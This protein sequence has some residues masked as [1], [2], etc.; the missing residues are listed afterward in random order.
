M[1]QTIVGLLKERTGHFAFESG[2]HGATW[3][4]LEKLFLEPG[5]VRPIVE[6]LSARLARHAPEAICGPLTEGAFLALLVALELGLPFAY[7]QRE[8]R[9][10]AAIYRIAPALAAELHGLRVA[11]IDD[12]INAGSA[13]SAT[14]AALKAAGAQP[15]ALGA[16]AVY[17]GAAAAL[18]SAQELPLE[19]LDTRP[20][21]IW[22][23]ADCPL[24]A[25]GIPL[26]Q[27][28]V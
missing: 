7:T 4:E 1:R 23:A 20:G 14:L 28:A 10:G 15:V 21:R 8:H 26:D 22:D 9:D 24:C 18:A 27:V 16:M 12:V 5:K 19:T 3:L 13:V 11:V 25:E 17:G 2:H 6:A